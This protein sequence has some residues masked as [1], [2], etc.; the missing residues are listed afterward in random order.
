MAFAI[1][2]PKHLFELSSVMV[3]MH[4]AIHDRHL[5]IA[6]TDTDIR[7]GIHG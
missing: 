4:T 7:E 3:S 5:D 1:T 2:W 6:S